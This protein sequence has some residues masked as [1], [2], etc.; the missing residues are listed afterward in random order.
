LWYNRGGELYERAVRIWET[1]TISQNRDQLNQDYRRAEA[2]LYDE[3]ALVN[4]KA[5]AVRNAVSR[6]FGV[7][8]PAFA[9]PSDSASGP[10][11]GE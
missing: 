8:F 5:A 10:K 11:V 3:A 9:T 7:E 6:Q 2:Q 4:E 1:P